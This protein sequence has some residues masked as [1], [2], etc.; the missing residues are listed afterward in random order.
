MTVA[1]IPFRRVVPGVDREG[2]G[3]AAEDV[4]GVGQRPG[5]GGVR[6]EVGVEPV[7]VPVPARE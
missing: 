6:D 1:A 7:V 4:R 5:L 2:A 3:R